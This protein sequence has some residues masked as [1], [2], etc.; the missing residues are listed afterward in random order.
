M[1]TPKET[2][3][4][5]LLE[6]LEC[7]ES[8]KYGAFEIQQLLDRGAIKQA[9]E[10]LNERGKT[11]NHMVE[12]DEQL[13]VLSESGLLEYKS[14]DWEE[15]VSLAASL[16]DITKTIVKVDAGT[17]D[18]LE[19]KGREISIKL[20]DLLDGKRAVRGYRDKKPEV[21]RTSISA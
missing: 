6:E 13:R 21:R 14:P 4:K 11:I 12:I 9:E 17:R 8:V 7:A 16:R 10:K 2:V 15:V 3:K 5:L 20:S 18:E 1:P 19:K